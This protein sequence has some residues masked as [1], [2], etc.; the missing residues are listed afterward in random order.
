LSYV[1]QPVEAD[2]DDAPDK[3]TRQKWAVSFN[4]I[5][6]CNDNRQTYHLF[7]DLL[8]KTEGATWFEKVMVAALIC[9]SVNITLVKHMI[10]AHLLLCEHY[11]GEAHATGKLETLFWKN[12]ASFSFEKFLT[13]M[14]EAFKELEDAGHEAQKVQQLLKSIKNDNVQVQT[15]LG[16][17]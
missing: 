16:I 6:F 10:C 5:Q 3:Y 12:E 14:S 7:K 17:I 1:I 11:V 9:Y 15:T 8:T 4:T 2:P 13:R